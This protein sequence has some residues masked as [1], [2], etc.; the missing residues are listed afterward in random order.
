MER[1][2]V[3][4]RRLPRVDGMPLVTGAATYTTDVVLPRMLYGKILRSPH[5]HARILGINVDRASRLTGVRGIITGRDTLGRVFGLYPDEPGMAVDKVRYLGEAV[6]AVAADDE[7]VVEESLHLIDVEYEPLP[8]VY[9]PL[10]A[11]APGAPLI[12]EALGTNISMSPT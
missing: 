10:E 2:V 6:A 12:H 5:P 3:I 11:M 9:D 8:A 1:H 4:G 7:D